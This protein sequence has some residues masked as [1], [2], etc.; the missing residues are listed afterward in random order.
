MELKDGLVIQDDET[1]TMTE[2]RPHVLL[3]PLQ[4]VCIISL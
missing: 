2:V 4:I 1:S 3:V